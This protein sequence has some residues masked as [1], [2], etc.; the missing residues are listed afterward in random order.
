MGVGG[1]HTSED[2]G[3]R[4]ATG[5]GRAKAVRVITNFRREP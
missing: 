4:L 5:F 2:A 3:E 1:P